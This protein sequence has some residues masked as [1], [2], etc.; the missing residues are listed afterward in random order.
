MLSFF[1]FA[2]SADI[3]LET[4]GK[5]AYIYEKTSFL[6]NEDIENLQAVQDFAALEL[7]FGDGRYFHP[8]ST[9]TNANA[10]RL[11]YRCAGR[12]KEGF[13]AAFDSFLREKYGL[14]DY[15]DTAWAD[16]FYMLALHDGL[17]TSEEFVKA[18]T[19][20][21]YELSKGA[22][23]TVQNLIKWLCI[24][25]KVAKSDMSLPVEVDSEYSMYY[26][27][28]YFGKM[29]SYGDLTKYSKATYA[30]KDDI[31]Y[32][33][34]MLEEYVLK[35]LGITYYEGTVTGTNENYA[36]GLLTRSVYVRTV[37]G[38]VTL[39]TRTIEGMPVFAALEKEIPVLGK[40]GCDTLGSVRAGERIRAYVQNGRVLFVRVLIP[41]NS[42]EYIEPPMVYRGT[43][44]LYDYITNALVL[45]NVVKSETTD[46][47][48]YGYQR[49]YLED[50]TTVYHNGEIVDIDRLN[51]DLAD[52]NCVVFLSYE[53][54]GGLDKVYSI[55]VD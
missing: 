31:A 5:G 11:I 53:Y 43:V 22:P 26:A 40:G 17:M 54:R 38:N 33:L 9:Y 49:F 42:F 18:L 35:S 50:N 6:D 41:K 28:M 39:Q 21:D 30:T 29:M 19:A 52:R 14:G 23:V 2:A 32:I 51:S 20:D 1:P 46:K 10:L 36:G 24:I 3:T 44:Y 13:E 7:L 4:A 15:T 48:M 34:G 55:V 12:E 16:G 37:D 8:E 47:S 27:S 45:D 25:L